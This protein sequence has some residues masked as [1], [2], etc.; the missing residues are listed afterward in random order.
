V[1]ETEGQTPEQTPEREPWTK[2]SDRL[3]KDREKAL[4]QQKQAQQ[5]GEALFPDAH[6]PPP[7]WDRD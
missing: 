1:S 5:K 2:R 3:G 6:Q 7:H 4:Q